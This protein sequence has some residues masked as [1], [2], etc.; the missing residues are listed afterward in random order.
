MFCCHLLMRSSLQAV[1]ESV[2][3]RQVVQ[4]QAAVVEVEEV[5]F[6]QEGRS[7]EGAADVVGSD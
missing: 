2:W 7:V 3:L 4:A 5:V 6:V 1:L